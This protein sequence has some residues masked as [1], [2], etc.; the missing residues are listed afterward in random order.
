MSAENWLQRSSGLVVPAMGFA[1][2]LAGQ[3]QPCPGGDCCDDEEWEG[4]ES[5]SPGSPPACT[6]R[7]LAGSEW[8]VTVGDWS[9]SACIN[10]DVGGTYVLAF[11][12]VTYGNIGFCSWLYTRQIDP[13]C[14]YGTPGVF[15][16]AMGL[17]G[18]PGGTGHW[19]FINMQVNSSGQIIRN[20]YETPRYF[21]GPTCVGEATFSFID[22]FSFSEPPPCQ[23]ANSADIPATRIA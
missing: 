4:E 3:M 1:N 15:I 10:C 8:E 12:S 9:D 16:L 13:M 6:T 5:C 17:F 18:E 23:G 20:Y 2:N 21:P 14:S 22:Q 7:D 19:M 11:D